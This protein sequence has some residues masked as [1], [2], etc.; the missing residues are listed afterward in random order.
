MGNDNNTPGPS[1]DEFASRPRGILTQKDREL[2]NG[3]YSAESANQRNQQRYQMRERIRNGLLDFLLL[4]KMDRAD[5]VQLFERDDG[6]D[7]MMY[8][9]AVEAVSF[10][11]YGAGQAGG[12]EVV[13]DILENGLESTFY[14]AYAEEGELF[15]GSVEVHA[16][17][18]SEPFPDVSESDLEI[19][20]EDAIGKHEA[21]AI[22]ERWRS[23]P[24]D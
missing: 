15:T 18:T 14:R 3:E 5:W 2:V 22:Y 19:H 6:V 12:P 10:L 7:P 23:S 13:V 8:A 4:T 16:D 17:E 24:P 9:A 21:R 20:D 1:V 11:T